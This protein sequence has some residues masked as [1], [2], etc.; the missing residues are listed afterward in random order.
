MK[1]LSE[2]FM[3]QP[4]ISYYLE[5]IFTPNLFVFYYIHDSDVPENISFTISD[6]NE[7]NTVAI[8]LQMYMSLQ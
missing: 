7:Y 6:C 4:L 2:L 8:F 5:A 3:V 1:F